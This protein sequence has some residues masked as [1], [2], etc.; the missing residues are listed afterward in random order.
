MKGIYYKNI[1]KS[2]NRI[3]AGFASDG[4]TISHIA[5]ILSKK[6]ADDFD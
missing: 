6:V 4:S 1:S 3:L 2:G 5:M